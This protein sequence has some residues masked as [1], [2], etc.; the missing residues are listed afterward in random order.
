VGTAAIPS[1]YDIV[2]FSDEVTDAPEI[3]V[4]KAARNSDIIF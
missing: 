3:K 4:G 2:A 1:A